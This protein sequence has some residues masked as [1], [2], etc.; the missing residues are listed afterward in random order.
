MFDAA[1]GAARAGRG[2]GRGSPPSVDGL[3]DHDDIENVVVLGM[4]G[5]GIAG[6][7]A[8]RASPGRSCRCRSSCTRATASRTSSASSTLVFAVSFSGDTEETVEAATEAAAAGRPHG[9]R[10]PAAASS[11]DLADELGRARACRSPTASR[12]RAPASA[13]S[14]IPPLVV[15]ER[16]GLFPGASAWIDAAVEQLDAAARPAR[17]RRQPGRASWPGASAARCRSST[18][19]AGSARSPRMRWKT[20]GQRERQGAGVLQRRCP[21]CATTRSAAGASTAT[22]PARCSGS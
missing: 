13:R 21:S 6:D 9:G 16:V 12:C 18:A 15:L 11:A 17:R 10:Q 22:S 19:A 14:A 20:P 7:V 1:A 4:G 2:R 5:S 3:P 8:A